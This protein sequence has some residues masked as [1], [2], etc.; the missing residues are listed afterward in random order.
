MLA[1]IALR[2]SALG[3]P[4][5]FLPSHGSNT[6]VDQ[7]PAWEGNPNKTQEDGGKPVEVLNDEPQAG[8]SPQIPDIDRLRDKI[9]TH[10]AISE[11]FR[12][13]D[14]TPKQT[15]AIKKAAIDKLMTFVG[16]SFPEIQQQYTAFK[17]TLSAFQRQP[18]PAAKA[19][20]EHTHKILAASINAVK[21]IAKEDRTT[22]VEMDLLLAPISIYTLEV[23]MA[24]AELAK[25]DHSQDQERITFHKNH[26][27]RQLRRRTNRMR[28]F[29][30]KMTLDD[31]QLAIKTG[32]L[33]QKIK[34]VAETKAIRVAKHETD[35]ITAAN[36]VADRAVQDLN[37]LRNEIKHL[38][39]RQQKRIKRVFPNGGYKKLDRWD[40][41]KA[42]LTGALTGAVLAVLR[43]SK[44]NHDFCQSCGVHK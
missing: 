15:W 4:E 11:S 23:K 9:E 41:V 32:E 17:T 44:K 42:V 29:T 18:T 34:F 14:E 6:T 31:E 28:H 21:T 36:I 13:F 30:E 20:F 25:A 8:E 27:D 33:E 38:T 12:I 16:E 40:P 39:D 10:K 24:E 43:R 3:S 35:Q 7:M 5:V 26:L 1:A 2:D 19:A 37:V 22:Q